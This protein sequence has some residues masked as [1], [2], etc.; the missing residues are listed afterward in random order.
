MHIDSEL[1]DMTTLLEKAIS[2][3]SELPDDEQDAVASIVLHEI[4]SEKRWDKLFEKSQDVLEEL[5]NEAVKEFEEGK[6]KNF[7]A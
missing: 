7:P 5:S 3:M 4:E 2:R 6:T 1:L